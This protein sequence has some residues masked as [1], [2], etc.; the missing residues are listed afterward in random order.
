LRL[1]EVMAE[2]RVLTATELMPLL[3]ERSIDLVG[4]QN[5]CVCAD[6]VFPQRR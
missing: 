3:R 2:H 5:S 6:L 1:R 4:C